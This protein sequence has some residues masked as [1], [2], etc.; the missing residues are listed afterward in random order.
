[1]GWQQLGILFV[2]AAALC[3][4]GFYRYVYFL[5]VGY[6]LAVAGIGAALLVLYGGGIPAVT[7]VQCVLFIL[8]GARLAGFLIWRERGNAAYRKTLRTVSG[9]EKKVTLPLKAGIWVSVSALYVVQASPVYFRCRSAAQDVLLPGIGAAVSA[10]AIVIEAL[11]DQQKTAQKAQDP[12]MVATHGLYRI[13]RCPNYW[14]EIQFWTGVLLG[15]LTAL[16]GAGQW[17]MALA[18]YGCIVAIMFS[19]A[20][21]LEKRQAARYGSLP[22]Y[23]EYAAHTPILLP[24]VPLYH[25][26]REKKA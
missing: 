21:R 13:V 12:N 20:Q 1:M 3:A 17:I 7:A 5:S 8:Y 6:G 11:A 2:V 9:D 23:Q 4:V 26:Y 15:G 16:H 18:G 22:A 14:G 25:L 24:L 10:A 19:G